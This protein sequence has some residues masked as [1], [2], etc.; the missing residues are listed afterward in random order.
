MSIASISQ[1]PENTEYIVSLA[2][3]VQEGKLI[4]TVVRTSF[5]AAKVNYAG[6]LAHVE[7]Q[8]HQFL[9]MQLIVMPWLMILARCINSPSVGLSTM[10]QRIHYE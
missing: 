10:S 8:G 2:L 9:R 7:C 3:S 1:K 5:K 4:R 6:Y